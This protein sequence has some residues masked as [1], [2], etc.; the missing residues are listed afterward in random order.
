MDINSTTEK[1]SQ[2]MARHRRDCKSYLPKLKQYKSPKRHP[3]SMKSFDE[4]GVENWKMILIEECP[5]QNRKQLEKR[6]GEYIQNEKSR[7]NSLTDVL[8]VGL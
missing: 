7:L 6:D 2:R 4:F 1:R 3:L 8:L 5:H